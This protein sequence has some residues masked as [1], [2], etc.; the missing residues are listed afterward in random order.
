M[1]LVDAGGRN[2]DVMCPYD[3]VTASTSLEIRFSETHREVVKGGVKG[4]SMFQ[5]RIQPP[6][7][8]TPVVTLCKAWVG[9]Q[10]KSHVWYNFD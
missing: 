7:V 2:T 6:Q 3:A 5:C 4:S 8:S 10:M 1:S 9:Q